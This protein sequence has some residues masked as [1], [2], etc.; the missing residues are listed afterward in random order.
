M[1]KHPRIPAEWPII[2]HDDLPREFYCPPYDFF[3]LL[4]NRKSTREFDPLC[5]NDLSALLWFSQ[6]HVRL[7]NFDQNRVRTPIPTI[8]SLASVQTIVVDQ[9]FSAWV[10][11]GEHHTACRLSS[12]SE[13]SREIRSDANNFFQVGGGSLLLFVASRSYLEQYYRAPDALVLREAGVL[14]G[15][16]ALL[17]EAFDLAFC[18]LG[19]AAEDWLEKLLHVNKQTI[20]PA[21]AAV[22]G[23]RKSAG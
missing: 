10:Y 4:E 18:P 19:T 6:R 8:G 7:D 13:V 21:G 15:T 20:V 16:M 22:V 14:L 12:A 17:A 23:G 9:R 5:L 1:I 3:D 11:N 2:G